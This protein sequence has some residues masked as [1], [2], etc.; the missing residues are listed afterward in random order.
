MLKYYNKRALGEEV[1]NR[2]GIYIP[3]IT[4]HLY[5]NKNILRRSGNIQ[6][7]KRVV[8]VYT[9]YNL[10]SFIN[11]LTRLEK[12]GKVRLTRRIKED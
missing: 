12:K 9:E 11:R 10:V 4:L 6:D 2:T 7:G 8:P 1:L 5:E 3:Y